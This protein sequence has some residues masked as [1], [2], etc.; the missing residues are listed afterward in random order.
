MKTPSTADATN[1]ASQV[2]V[3]VVDAVVARSCQR[4]QRSA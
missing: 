4:D 1:S 3:A 2:L